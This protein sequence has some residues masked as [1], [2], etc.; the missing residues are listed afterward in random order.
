MRS[1]RDQEA[2]PLDVVPDDQNRAIRS[3]EKRSRRESRETR[4]AEQSRQGLLK[5]GLRFAEELS[6]MRLTNEQ[7]AGSTFA[8]SHAPWRG[9]H[10]QRRAPG[11]SPG[12]VQGEQDEGHRYDP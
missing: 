2:L 1:P 9:E 7:L 12:A 6:R 4:E 8:A 3:T 5:S 10:S 11:R